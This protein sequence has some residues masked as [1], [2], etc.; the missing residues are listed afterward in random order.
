MSKS[1]GVLPNVGDRIKVATE[2]GWLYGKV[3]ELEATK[4]ETPGTYIYV[5]WE[6]SER[7]GAFWSTRALD[8]EVVPPA[9]EGSTP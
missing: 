2:R 5:F 8:W 7:L 4:T 6:H 9:T 1:D 3:K